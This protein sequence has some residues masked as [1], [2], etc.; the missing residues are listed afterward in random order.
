[1]L[2]RASPWWPRGHVVAAALVLAVF[3]VACGGGD[4]EVEDAAFSRGERL[5]ANNCAACHGPA[6][7]GTAT[8]PPLVHVIYEPSHHPDEAFHQAVAQGVVAHHWGFGPM[9]AVPGLERD[10]IDDIIAYVRALQREA[11]IE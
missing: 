1:M 4:A 5:F 6:G 2:S 3:A 11:G 8:G 7:V 9:P 10:E